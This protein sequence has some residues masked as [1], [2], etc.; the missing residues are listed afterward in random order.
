MLE[1]FFLS[2]V[3]TYLAFM[4]YFYYVTSRKK[5]SEEKQDGK[6]E[7]GMASDE[8]KWLVF[9]IIVAIIANAI[10]LSPL[11]PSMQYNVYAQKTPS[12]IIEIKVKDYQFI[13]P[14]NPIKIK[15]GELVE[16]V[17]ESEDVAYGFGVFRKD[18][19]L[20]F[21]MQVVPGYENRIKWVFNEPGVYSIRSTEYSGP[22]HP[23]M[24]LPNVI[25]VEG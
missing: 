8:K 20:V 10:T 25:I 3:L 9:L 21:Q 11:I 16:F 14:E 7:K 18:G 17:V 6:E 24:F 5:S 13:L 15:A 2:L 1:I 22:E 23:K 19:T 12:K 4:A